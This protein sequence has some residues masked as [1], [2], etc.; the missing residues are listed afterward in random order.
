[1]SDPKVSDGRAR[2]R[3]STC[4]VCEELYPTDA[5]PYILTLVDAN[6]DDEVA[7]Y[8]CVACWRAVAARAGWTEEFGF[9]AGQPEA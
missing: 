8:C 4:S 9:L 1:M 6:N 7:G 2:L 5:L 3:V